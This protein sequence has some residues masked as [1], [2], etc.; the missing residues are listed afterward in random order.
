MIRGQ[1]VVRLSTDNFHGAS[2]AALSVSAHEVGHAI[3]DAQEYGPLRLRHSILPVTNIGSMAAFPLFIAGMLFSWPMLMDLGIVF[4]AGVVLFHAVTLPVEFNASSR[5]MAQLEDRG[6]LSSEETRSAKKVLDAAALN[7]CGRRCHGSHESYP[8]ADS[9]RRN[10]RLIFLPDT[11]LLS[12]NLYRVSL[13]TTFSIFNK[14]PPNYIFV[15][16]FFLHWTS[17]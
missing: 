3:Q 15:T 16:G 4:F 5:A 14:F 9:A 13:Q 2:L 6:Y 8:A 7:L 17:P 1:K 10:G 11:E 12:I